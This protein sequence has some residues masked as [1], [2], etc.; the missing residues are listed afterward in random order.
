MFHC[1]IDQ[2]RF[3]SHIDRSFGSCANWT[4]VKVP[5]PP[6]ARLHLDLSSSSIP[7]LIQ[8][9]VLE[10]PWQSTGIDSIGK[11]STIPILTQMYCRVKL[12][13]WPKKSSMLNLTHNR[14][15]SHLKRMFAFP[16][17]PILVFWR[18][19]V[20]GTRGKSQLTSFL[21]LLSNTCA[22]VHRTSVCKIRF[23]NMRTFFL[24]HFRWLAISEIQKRREL[25]NEHCNK[26]FCKLIVLA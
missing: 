10:A 12:P 19:H 15:C 6:C 24:H 22:H 23:L 13:P 1:Y 11:I 8:V 26:H 25:A 20:C 5:L 17:D 7:T 18:C 14:F 9:Y 2:N 16:L 21:F 3:H 4:Q